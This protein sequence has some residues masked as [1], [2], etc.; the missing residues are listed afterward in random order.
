M[1][2]PILETERLILRGPVREDFP[3][4]AEMW[5]DAGV[6]RFIGGKP[7]SEE[8]SW[9]KFLR[10][11]GHWVVLGFGYWSVVEKSSGRRI[12]EIGFLSMKRDIEPSFH[13]TPEIGWA[14][15]PSA[16][17]KGYASEAVRAALQWGEGYFG[18]VKMV[19]IIDPENAASIRVALKCGFRE[20]LRT[21][22]KGSPTILFERDPETI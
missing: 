16:Q 18:R 3:S 10:V 9:A 21:T 22:Y 7:F 6:T 17:G 5:A 1:E 19:C 2:I 15:A 12:G 13:E 8:D 14:L 4:Y 20:K 11:F